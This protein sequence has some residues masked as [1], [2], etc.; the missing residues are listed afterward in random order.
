MESL[1]CDRSK[2]QIAPRV[3]TDA[4]A[5]TKKRW[6][7]AISIDYLEGCAVFQSDA[8]VIVNARGGDVGVLKP[9][10]HL[11]DVGLVIEH[12]GGDRRS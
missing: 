9:L 6:P 2:A 1:P 11:D 5:P 10:L 8:A 7:G 4:R 12:V 3:A